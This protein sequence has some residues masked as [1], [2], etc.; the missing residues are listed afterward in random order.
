MATGKGNFEM[1]N[2]HRDDPVALAAGETVQANGLGTATLV[3]EGPQIATTITLHDTFRVPDMIENL[4]SVGMIDD[5]GGAVLF[6][7]GYCY[8]YSDADIPDHPVVF[9]K[10]DAVGRKMDGQHAI[11]RRPQK[12]M[13]AAAPVQGP[14]QVWHRRYF[15]LGYE[16]LGRASKMVSGVPSAEVVLNPVAGAVCRPCAEEKM[17]RSPYPASSSKSNLMELV[18][19]VITGPFARSVGESH[20]LITMLEDKTGTLVG[21]I[22]NKCDAGAVLRSRLPQLERK[23][24]TKLKRVRF[25]GAKEFV[26]RPMRASYEERGIDVETTLPHS[27]QS[28]GKAAHV[29]KTIKD[30]V[31][32]A[33]SEDAVGEE[34]W[35]EAAVPAVYVMNR[36]PKA[37]NDKTPWEMLTGERP[38]VSGLV[39]W[40]SAAFALKPPWQQRGMQRRSSLD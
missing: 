37:G 40:G 21:P 7:N 29:N 14:A 19:V 11:G 5:G 6:A 10:A 27:L 22:K 25:D 33:L 15:H 32:A 18:H 38:D 17:V 2:A 31:R 39:V 35:A 26:T 1:T 24:R 13:M 23:C 8:V 20:Y 4:M 34:M 36:S 12:A 16:N 30:R 3:P 28:N 9:A